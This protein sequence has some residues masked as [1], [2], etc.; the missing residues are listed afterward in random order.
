MKIVCP[1]C[2]KSKEIQNNYVARARKNGLR[3]FCSRKCSG[4]ARRKNI[5]LAERKR[6][7]KEYD[8]QYRAL[9]LARI[10]ADKAAYYQRT[11]DPEK[12]A[13]NPE[14]ADASAR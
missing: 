8:V 14:T 6:R 7:K 12:A 9:N 10:K 3:L 11:R 13:G 1:Q 4:L 2:R 5:P